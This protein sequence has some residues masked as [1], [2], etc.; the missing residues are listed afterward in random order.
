MA[1][2]RAFS[3]RTLQSGG[4]KQRRGVRVLAART[5]GAGAQQQWQHA[6]QQQRQQQHQQQHD[7]QQHAASFGRRAALLAAASGAGLT[8]TLAPAARAA[9]GIAPPPQGFKLLVDKIDGY[10]FAYPEAWTPVT[11][12]GND[13]FLRNPFSIEENLF[14]DVSS[15]SSSRFAS[16]E[17]L[18]SPMDAAQRLLDQYLNK[19]FMSTRLGEP[20]APALRDC[21]CAP[22]RSAPVCVPLAARRRRRCVCNSCF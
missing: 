4:T 20:A 14:V 11:T 9:A 1:Q 16:V 7:E 8:L 13:V 17:D 22:L 6:Q 19:E 2:L 18:G 21:D 10:S 15:P 3:S 12:S 5:G